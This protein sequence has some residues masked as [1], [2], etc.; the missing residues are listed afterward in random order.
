MSE[1]NKKFMYFII[2]CVVVGGLV[3]VVLGGNNNKLDSCKC[4]EISYKSKSNMNNDE[5]KYWERCEEK[6]L[7]VNHL[8]RD[9]DLSIKKKK[10]K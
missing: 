6:Y 1:D 7:S 2:G 5:K 10:F 3:G 8:E 9:C 4:L